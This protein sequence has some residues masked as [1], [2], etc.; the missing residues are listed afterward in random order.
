[1]KP[2]V[3]LV[4]S[5]AELG[6]TLGGALASRFESLHV[7]TLDE[8]MAALARKPWAAVVAGYDLAD[9]ETGLEVLQIARTSLPC[10][11][12]LLHTT[13]ASSGFHE[14]ARRLACPHFIT[15]APAPALAGAIERALAELLEPPPL[16]L[17]PDLRPVLDDVIQTRSPFVREFLRA[18]RAAAESSAPVYLYGEPAT[19]V[20]RAAT[21]L[22]QWRREWKERGGR[23]AGEPPVVVL[24][25]PS[26]RERPQD[27]PL[28]AA[29]CLLEHSRVTGEP[30]R[31]LAP[32]AVEE[33]LKRPWFGNVVELATVL[34]Q[35]LRR[36]GGRAVIEAEDLPRDVQP[37]WRPSQCAKDDG[38]RDCV[39]RQL[40]LARTVS[41]AARLEGCS[42]ANYIRLMRRLGIIRADV[43]TGA[44]APRW[45]EVLGLI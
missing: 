41:H 3:L 29:R 2:I 4:E 36:S 10:A 8:A 12:R 30:G 38:Q 27:V 34:N 39:L 23:A 35:A 5:D 45:A 18:L 22:R 16:E 25:V 14:D 24:R 32:G 17:P 13:I 44:P 19:G 6:R 28:L 1:V 33:L 7:A 21:M 31:R 9:G 37:A 40:R 42:R 15:E 11:F 26:V 43:P 20:T